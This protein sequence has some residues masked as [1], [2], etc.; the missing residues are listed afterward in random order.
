MISPKR[1]REYNTLH[2][3][4]D[5]SGEEIFTALVDTM[6]KISAKNNVFSMDKGNGKLS[7]T[8]GTVMAVSGGAFKLI[9][10]EVHAYSGMDYGGTSIKCYLI[11]GIDNGKYGFD[12][13]KKFIEYIAPS[14]GE[15]AEGIAKVLRGVSA[16]SMG[17]EMFGG[18]RS[19]NIMGAI[20]S[21]PAFKGLT[22][23]QYDDDPFASISR[24]DN[25]QFLNKIKTSGNGFFESFL[26]V[27]TMENL[28]VKPN[29]QVAPKQF[30][31][32]GNV[33]SGLNFYIGKGA[34][35]NSCNYR[36]LRHYVSGMTL[37]VG[38]ITEI[39]S[40]KGKSSYLEITLT[41][42][43]CFTPYNEHLN[44]FNVKFKNERPDIDWEQLGAES[45][46]RGRVVGDANSSQNPVTDPA[47][48]ELL[49]NY[50]RNINR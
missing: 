49:E 42:K 20:M 18:G 23:G 4:K 15:D 27:C 13:Y 14:K 12:N 6:P 29:R 43:P 26:R 35:D 41:I 48:R 10:N 8:L 31:H 39:G 22:I 21:L 40:G 33:I 44:V 36:F 34:D 17:K 1:Y 11:D 16:Y 25:E 32:V 2:V 38:D 5:G 47:N 30:E 46:E 3:R 24:D 28:Y 45:L 19:G 37:N 7:E 50:W 9:S